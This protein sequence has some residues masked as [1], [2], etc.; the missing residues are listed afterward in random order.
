MYIMCSKLNLKKNKLFAAITLIFILWIIFLLVLG[1]IN[2]R[3][4]TFYDALA[5]N[6]VS[7]NYASELPLLR[8]LLEPFAITAFILDFEFTWLFS[9]LIFYPILRIAYLLL[10]KYGK[11]QSKKYSYLTYV[12][13]DVLNFAFKAPYFIAVF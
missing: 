11:I 12:V 9:F 13:S 1:V 4:I 8:Y 7:S 5:L 10:K 2:R 3:V 6:D